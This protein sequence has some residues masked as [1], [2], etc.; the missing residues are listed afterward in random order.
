[1]HR[2]HRDLRRAAATLGAL[3]ATGVVGCAGSGGNAGGSATTSDGTGSRPDGA[4]PSDASSAKSPGCGVSTWPP[5][6]HSSLDVNGTERTYTVEIPDGYDP[7]TPHV[8][9]L[10]WHGFMVT[11][12]QV[13][14]P[15][16][17]GNLGRFFVLQ[18]RSEGRAIFVAP[19]GLETA[20]LGTTGPG[21]DNANGRDVAFARALVDSLRGSYCIDDGRIF[22][23]G[24][25]MGGY[26]S[27]Q[28]GCEMGDVFRAVASI[29]GGGPLETG[30]AHCTNP[31][32]AWITHGNQ[33]PVNPF[34]AGQ[35]SRDHWASVNH[36]GATTTPVGPAGCVAYDGCD[37]GYPVHWCEFD[38]GH[39]IPDFA[40]E[41]IWNF[42]AQF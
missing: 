42:F 2:V 40:P 15:I 12:D 13:A 3:L 26:L 34:L 31:M 29:I 9:V 35:L 38:G 7:N 11:A 23:V 4:T 5:S 16:T 27:N 21:W 36:C 6:G 30:G 20:L 17:V 25:S 41:G 19:Q 28:L 22:S 1:M 10:A 8:L 24:V 39:L 37:P 33:D 32:A 14:S 18:P